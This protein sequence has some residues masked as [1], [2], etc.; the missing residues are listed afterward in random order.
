[1]PRLFWYFVWRVSY[2]KQI[3]W[4]LFL[5][6]E[7]LKINQLDNIVSCSKYSHVVA[8]FLITR[9]KRAIMN[10]GRSPAIHFEMA[11][12]RYHDFSKFTTISRRWYLDGCNFVCWIETRQSSQSYIRHVQCLFSP[13]V[14]GSIWFRNFFLPRTFLSLLIL[15]LFFFTTNG[16][17]SILVPMFSI[18]FWNPHYSLVRPICKRF[19]LH[20]WIIIS[21]LKDTF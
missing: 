13:I 19:R 7:T 15:F 16:I 17:D 18:K 12:S 21:F 14:P 1:M 8:I 3:F 4:H 9:P 11:L 5:L 6:Q 10:Y 20:Q 2:P